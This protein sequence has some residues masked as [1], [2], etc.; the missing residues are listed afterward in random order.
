MS[1]S[2]RERDRESERTNGV[3]DISVFVCD[4]M[5]V[6]HGEMRV[7]LASMLCVVVI[8]V[9]SSGPVCVCVCEHTFVFARM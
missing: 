7:E 6:L 9:M 3:S 8:V 1:K 2:E 4:E 5:F